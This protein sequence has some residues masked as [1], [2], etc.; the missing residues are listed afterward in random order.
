M[1]HG[2]HGVGAG[3][4]SALDSRGQGT[5]LRLAGAAGVTELLQKD[6]ILEQTQVAAAHEGEGFCGEREVIGK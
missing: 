2:S 4:R 5:C 6:P 3:H 1:E